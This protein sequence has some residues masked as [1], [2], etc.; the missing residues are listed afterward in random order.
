MK[1]FTMKENNSM[2]DDLKRLIEH[3]SKTMMY[4]GYILHDDF[5][6]K[7]K[8]WY[9]S[10]K[11]CPIF[12]M[13]CV[14]LGKKY[15]QVRD[16]MGKDSFLFVVKYANEK[17][18]YVFFDPKD[19]DGCVFVSNASVKKYGIDGESEYNN[20]GLSEFLKTLFKENGVDDS[21]KFEALIVNPTINEMMKNGFIESFLTK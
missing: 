3:S 19:I 7:N 10:E 14:E 15:Y 2:L 13:D 18:A 9:L 17:T 8:N 5:E 4:R 11:E 1:T 6:G 20:Y 21:Y 12:K 16:Y